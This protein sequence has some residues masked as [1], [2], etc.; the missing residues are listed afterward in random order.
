M[1]LKY[2]KSWP[3]CPEG[4]ESFDTQIVRTAHWNDT[5]AKKHSEEKMHHLN[6]RNASRHSHY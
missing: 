4:D 6:C 1:L 2:Q 3:D 5:H